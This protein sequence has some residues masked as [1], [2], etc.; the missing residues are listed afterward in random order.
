MNAPLMEAVT[1]AL[2]AN[3]F[4]VL[5]FNFRGVGGSTGTHGSGIHEIEDVDSA[6]R[7]AIAQ[8]PRLPFAIAGWS[9]GAATA[10]NWQARSGSGWPYV[11]IAPPVVSDHSPP[12]P[13]EDEL[14]PAVRTF[15]LGDRDQFT[16][17][18][19]LTE[20]AARIG[21]TVEILGGSDHFFY[22]REDRV[23]DILRQAV[24]APDAGE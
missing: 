23:A 1:R 16:S 6:V 22:F 13:S 19:A 3:D 21:A 5:R 14:A 24:V 15:I 18:E 17:S 9:F 11:G 10:L 2:V 20:Y 8:H 12:L 7:Y 4:A